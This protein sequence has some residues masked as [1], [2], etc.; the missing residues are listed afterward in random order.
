M[1]MIYN[2]ALFEELTRPNEDPERVLQSLLD[3]TANGSQPRNEKSRRPQAAVGLIPCSPVG[4]LLVGLSSHGIV[5]IHFLRRATDL[6]DAIAKLRRGCE[7]VPDQ[8]AI[9]RVGE[10]L[11]RFMAG[12]ES[13]LISDVDLS[14][15]AGRFQRR[16]L[17]LLL[18]VGPGAILTYSSLAA[19]AG[20]PQASRA[21]GG[22]MHDNPIPVYVPC[23]RVVRSDLSLGGYGGGLDVKRKLLEVEGFSFSPSGL[24][25]QDG[26]VWGNRSTEIFCRP[27]CRALARADRRNMLLFRDAARAGVGGMRACQI[28]QR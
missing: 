19:W 20:A 1:P 10:E 14:L 11:S 16:V 6:A 4:S 5:M 22:A 15:V 18:Q 13:A 25:A 26:A 17:E 12:D 28:C 27:G 8:S 2:R 23:H 21:V 7:P 24:V 3:T 9:Q